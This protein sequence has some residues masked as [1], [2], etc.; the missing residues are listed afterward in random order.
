MVTTSTHA[1]TSIQS[2]SSGWSYVDPKEATCCCCRA[3]VVIQLISVPIFLLGLGLTIV[4][5]I[6]NVQTEGWDLATIN[7]LGWLCI[8][9]GSFLLVLALLGVVAAR[10]GSTP[11]LFSWRKTDAESQTFSLKKLFDFMHRRNT[12]LDA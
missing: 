5:A 9:T 2:R 10:C 1:L 6:L 8:G 7:L 4:G 11:L 12:G 3:A